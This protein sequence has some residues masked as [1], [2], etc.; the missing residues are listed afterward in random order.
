MTDEFK[1][2]IFQGARRMVIWGESRADVLHRLE[3]NGIP[4]DEAQQMYERALAER[5]STLRTDAIKQTVQGLGLLLAAF[6]L[7]NRLAE[8]SG[9]ISQHGVSA[10]L[11]TGFLGAWR[12]FKGIF[13]YLLA[14]SREG[15]LSDHD[16]DDEE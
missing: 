7:F 12:F 14:R 1:D 4:S 10:I 3:V 8:G 16:D 11:L 15:S 5:V 6:Y 9:A 13:G 2:R